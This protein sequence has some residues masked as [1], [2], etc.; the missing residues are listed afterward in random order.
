ML[1]V[2]DKTTRDSHDRKV[3]EDNF[4][5]LYLASLIVLGLETAMAVVYRLVLGRTLSLAYVIIPVT[6]ANV[7]LYLAAPKVDLSYQVKRVATYATVAV[8]L[9]VGAFW[10]TVIGGA[11]LALAIYMSMVAFVA[12]A[13]LL[14]PGV[15]ASLFGFALASFILS[16]FRPSIYDQWL[17]TSTILHAAVF[18]A[19]AWA[20]SVMLYQSHHNMYRDKTDIEEKNK[21]LEEL[22]V[23]DR[24][25]GVYNRYKLEDELAREINRVDRYGHSLTLLIVDLDSF[26]SVNDNYGHLAGDKVLRELALVIRSCLRKT[27]VFGRWGGEEFMV[28]C[29]DSNVQDALV[30]AERIRER[31]GSA[32]VLHNRAVTLSIGIDSYNRGEGQEAFVRRVDSLL[33]QAKNHGGN[34][35]VG[36]YPPE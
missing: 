15:T 5:R 33:Y 29:P 10:N 34:R 19:L 2:E 28:L 12:G 11:P 21:L 6:S 26:K 14:K 3:T 23:T 35:V 27:D 13:F 18:T 7:L 8:A 1:T 9:L 31:V 20:I 24:L 36:V 32:D 30:V 16:S 4:Y 22:Y 17:H 25:T